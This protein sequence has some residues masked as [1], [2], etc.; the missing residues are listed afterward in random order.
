MNLKFFGSTAGYTLFDHIR[1]EEI[2]EETTVELA[3]EKL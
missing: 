1:N 2:W 3:D